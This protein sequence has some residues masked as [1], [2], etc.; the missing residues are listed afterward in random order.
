MRQARP[1]LLALALLATATGAR[2]SGVSLRWDHCYGDGGVRNKNT[3]KVDCISAKAI[4]K[5]R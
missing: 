5:P 1:L 4:K 2:A 3:V